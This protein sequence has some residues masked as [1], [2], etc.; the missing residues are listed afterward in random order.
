MDRIKLRTLRLLYYTFF[1]C[2]TSYT[3]IDPLIPEISKKLKVGYDKIGLVLLLGSIFALLS[4]LIS[5]KLC[6]KFD[7]K[8]ILLSGLFL[9]FLGSLLFGIYFNLFIFIFI[10]ILFRLGQGSIDSS[11]HTYIARL[12]LKNSSPLFLKL[13]LQWYLGAVMGPFLISLNLYLKINPKY[14]F[15]LIAIFFAVLLSFFY[16]VHPEKMNVRI[17]QRQKILKLNLLR[18]TKKLMKNLKK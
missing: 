18:S 11:V 6:D 7:V 3:I 12:F 13:S 4:S 17:E 14:I 5:G 16:R 15:L 2:G 1:L 10:I 9:S 8:K